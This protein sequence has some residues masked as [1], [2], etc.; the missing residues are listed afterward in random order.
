MGSDAHASKA[1]LSHTVFGTSSEYH[2]KSYDLGGE[3]GEGTAIV[4]T[5][6][7]AGHV[8]HENFSM[9]SVHL[10]HRFQGL[11]SQPTLK[12]GVFDRTFR[13]ESTRVGLFSL[14]GEELL[15]K[16]HYVYQ[17]GYLP[18]SEEFQST[19]TVREILRGGNI[20]LGGSYRWADKWR[21]TFY[22]QN[23]FFN[24]DN[25]RLNH[26]TGLF[27]GLSTGDPWIWVG[28]GAGRMSNT[29]IDA[30]YWTPLEFYNLGPRLD[31]AF[32]FY[33]K[34]RFLWGL[35]L[36]WFKDVKTGEGTGYYSMSKLFYKLTPGLEAYAALE[37]IQSQQD[38]NVWKSS[39]TTVGIA[40]S[41]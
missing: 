24:D 12:A 5:R 17:V 4:N 21:S 2:A 41:W 9:R 37:S 20:S 18:M 8:L 19:F 32:S 29:K 36:N 39:A 26:D 23:H 34:W 7:S 13:G 1:S 28:A 15:K 27:Y 22:L 16:F 33:E 11:R 3:W 40:G 10:G 38:G 25:T 6:Y 30:G 14:S 31:M 35:N